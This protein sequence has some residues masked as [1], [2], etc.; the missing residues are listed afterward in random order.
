VNVVILGRLINILSSL[1]CKSVSPNLRYP[2]PRHSDKA[3]SVDLGLTTP[4]VPTNTIPCYIGEPPVSVCGTG[5]VVSYVLE[6]W[7]SRLTEHFT[8]RVP[9]IFSSSL[10]KTHLSD[11]LVRISCV[12]TSLTL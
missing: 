7:T 10:W 4:T 8:Q 3:T 2:L 9:R 11:N 5:S 12:E 6:T 1:A